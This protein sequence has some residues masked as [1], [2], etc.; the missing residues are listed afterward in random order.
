MA[1]IVHHVV[2]VSPQSDVSQSLKKNAYTCVHSFGL[3]VLVSVPTVTIFELV[4]IFVQYGTVIDDV[5]TVPEFVL[6]DTIV[7]VWLFT[8]LSKFPVIVQ[9]HFTSSPQPFVQFLNVYVYWS[10][11]GVGL[12]VIFVVQILSGFELAEIVVP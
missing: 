7:T 5:V 4:E 3:A 2:T 8:V 1:V 12:A 6:F 9:F 11:D 10:L